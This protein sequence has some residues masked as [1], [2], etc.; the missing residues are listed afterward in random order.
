M[1]IIWVLSLQFSHG[2]CAGYQ[3]NDTV[4]YTVVKCDCGSEHRCELL[5]KYKVKEILKLGSAR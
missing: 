4:F 1:F 2:G 3:K 5:K